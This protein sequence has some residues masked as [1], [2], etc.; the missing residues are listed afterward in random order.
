MNLRAEHVLGESGL[1][2]G[3]DGALQQTPAS[4][5][6]ANLVFIEEEVGYLREDVVTSGEA[7]RRSHEMERHSLCSPLREGEEAGEHLM[8]GSGERV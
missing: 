2:T 1:K 7:M 8:P 3:F 4:A 5:D 6:R